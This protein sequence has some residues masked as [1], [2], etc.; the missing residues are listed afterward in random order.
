MK[1]IAEGIAYSGQEHPDRQSCTFP[2]ICVL[3]SGRWICT[4]RAAP[5]KAATDTQRA[6]VMTSDDQGISWSDPADPFE[7]M[8]VEGKPGVIR[9]AFMTAMAGKE[10]LATLFWQ[11]CSDPNLPL[12]NDKTGGVLDLRIFAARSQDDGL[13]WSRPERVDASPF[14]DGPLSVTGPILRLAN[15][16]LACQFETNKTYYDTSPWYQSAVFMFSTDGGRTWSNFAVTASDPEGRL[17]YWDQ[18]SRVMSDGRILNLLWTYNGEQGEYLN[19]HAGESLDNGRTWSPVWDTGVSGQP[20][21]AVDLGDKGVGMA[22]VDRTEAP[23]IKMR[24]SCDRGR[25][26]RAHTEIV[27]YRLEAEKQSWCGDTMNEAWAEMGTWSVGLPAT[28]LSADG[29]V[30]CFYYAGPGRDRTDIRWAR[31]SVEN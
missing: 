25:T 16:D 9:G 6:L 4:F 13:S 17:F 1:V 19:I 29:D 23:A 21:A 11:D 30:L 27:L 22:Y 10:V 31:V 15:D 20:A 2:G 7:P 5:A 18:R 14:V 24:T 12:Y 26:W 3:P 8:T 28:E